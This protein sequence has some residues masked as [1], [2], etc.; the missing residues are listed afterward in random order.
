M[1]GVRAQFGPGRVPGRGAWIALG[2]LAAGTTVLG[3]VAAW[4]V[5]RSHELAQRLDAV[6]DAR[7]I[8][9]Q[10]VPVRPEPPYGDSARLFLRA[11]DAAWAPALR[12]LESGTMVGIVPVR[13]DF[14]AAEGTARVELEY[15][16]ADVLHDY[17]ARIN[18]GQP[19]SNPTGRWTLLETHAQANPSSPAG[20]LSPAA[21]SGG[22]ATIRANWR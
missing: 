17:L 6:V 5:R 15:R 13:V 22:L 11:R 12:S 14:D 4:Q 10:Q 18:E 3:A 7:R 20:A 16:D 8:A 1:R 9:A 21:G 2:V 19:P